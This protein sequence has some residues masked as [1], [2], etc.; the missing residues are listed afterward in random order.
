MDKEGTIKLSDFGWATKTLNSNR[1][2]FCGTADYV[3]PELVHNVPYDYKIDLWACGVLLY[4]MLMGNAPFSG[5]NDH[6]T[7]Q[8][9]AQFD[10]NKDKK[11][12]NLSEEAKDLITKILVTDSDKRME[13]EDILDH[14]W[15]TSLEESKENEAHYDE[16]VVEYH[17]KENIAM[18]TNP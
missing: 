1:L 10:L 13:Y 3:A 2:T 16:P 9:I 4:E 5:K 12:D 11:Y 7:F 18:N 8:K 14:P 6:E 17:E 15:F